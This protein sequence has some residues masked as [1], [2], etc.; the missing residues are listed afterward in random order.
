MF[1]DIGSKNIITSLDLSNFDTRKVNTLLWFLHGSDGQVRIKELN[2]TNCDFSNVSNI[3]NLLDSD[4]S[5]GI[6]NPIIRC[7]VLA[8][9]RILSDSLPNR[10]TLS[11]PGYIVT[12]LRDQIDEETMAALAAKNWQIKDLVAQYRFD[13]N[14]YEDLMPEFNPEFTEDMYEVHDS[15]SEIVID[16]FRWKNGSIHNGS[17]KDV[18]ESDDNDVNQY[19][20]N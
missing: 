11:T 17:G 10:S 13:A 15:V 20:I 3:G 19:F 1:E 5:N 14:T 12:T 6:D 9:I 16:G 7:S 8:S 4:Y 2:I 18:L